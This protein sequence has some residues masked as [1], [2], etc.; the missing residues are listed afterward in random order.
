[1][2]ATLRAIWQADGAF[3]SGSIAFSYGIEGA[4]A[5]QPDL[6]SEAFAALV[7]T[8][9]RQRWASY[10]RIAL[11]RAFRARDDLDAIAAIDREV[12]ASTLV[13]TLRTGSRRHGASFL[14]SHARLGD[15]RAGRLREAVRSGRCLGHIAVM[16]GAVWSA[17]LPDASL[18]QLTSGYAVAS[19][20]ITAAVRLGAIGALPGQ[21]LLRDC[22]PLI[23][24]LAADE[25]SELTELSSFLPFLEI[26]SARHAR[27]EVRLFAN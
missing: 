20:M 22:L 21:A 26:A 9:L 14:A 17:T 7:Q 3:P 15:P 5:L 24:E 2:L 16:Q 4:L 11:L 10:D 12:E 25:T 27:S 13:E 18:A 8:I 23:A 6:G 19:S 1:M